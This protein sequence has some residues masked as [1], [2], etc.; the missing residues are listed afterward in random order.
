V[1]VFLRVLLLYA[2][3]Y[4]SESVIHTF[5]GPTAASK[6]LCTVCEKP[7]YFKLKAVRCGGCDI[8]FHCVCLKMKDKQLSF[9]ATC[10]KSSYTCSA[11]TKL[12]KAARSDGTNAAV[13][14]SLRLI[15]FSR[16]TANFC[17]KE[18]LSVQIDAVHLNEKRPWKWFRSL[19]LRSVNWQMMSLI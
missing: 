3:V 1:S 13:S 10:G 6:A 18:S 17:S 15:P 11:R 5:S 4:L 8:R 14:L 2:R 16:E 9:Y 19:L 7:F 12:Q